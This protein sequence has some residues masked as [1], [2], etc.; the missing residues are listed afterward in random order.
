MESGRNLLGQETSPYLLQHA[1]NP[2]HWRPWNAEAL[3]EAKQ[4]DRPILLSIGYAACHWCHVMAHESFENTETADL[5]NK[6]F[7]NIKV[8]REERPD[9]DHIYM[10]ALHALGQQGGWPLTMF[11]T[12]DGKPMIGGTYWPPEPRYGRPSFRQVLQSIDSSWR[13]QRNEMESRGLTLADHLAKLSE[14]NSGSGISPADLTRVGDALRS[15]VDPVNG[16]IGGAPKF[17]NAPIFRFFWNEMFR[18][19]DPSFGEALR[20]MLEAMNAGGIYDHLGG[21]YARYSTDA[22]WLVPHFEKMLYDNAQILE[23]LALAHSLWP[24]P[25]FAERAHETVDW[26]MREMRVGDAFAASLDADQDGEEG[27]FYVWDEEEVDTALGDAARRFKTAYDVTRGG[28]WEDRTVLRRITPCGSP[29]EEAGL[30]VS[31]AK[32]F[33]LRESRSTPGRDDKVLAD[34]NGLTIAALAR[35]GAVFAEPG[36]LATAR[37]AFDFIMTKLRG[38]DKR[39]LHAWR[40]GHP[41][42][43][44]ILDDYASIARAAL[45]LFEASGE[46]GDLEAARRLASDAIDLFGDGSGGFFLTARDAADVPGA[47]PRQAH[48]GAT[49][50]GVGLLAETFVRLWHLSDEARWAEAAEGLIRSVSGLPEGLGGSPLTLMSADMLA[51]GGSIVIDGPLDDPA[52]KELAFA[53]LRAPDPSLTVLRLDRRLWPNGSPRDDLLRAESPIAMLCQGQTC[54]LPVTTPETLEALMRARQKRSAR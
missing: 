50:S 10:T 1:H 2:V 43:R 26:L 22:Q 35:A 17:P 23:L 48:D 33:A 54:S 12:P 49:P 40:E 46:P 39:L 31:R 3:A 52:A 25:T 18:R 16:G 6:L 14:L 38:P 28:N 44:A 11:L 20:A 7:V 51:R 42:A 9:I 8:D 5:M 4:R 36:W 27:L 13:T 29:E 24:D 30:A 37:A 45:A 21:G 41:G 47:R 19:R 34:W 53:A 15:A 32:L